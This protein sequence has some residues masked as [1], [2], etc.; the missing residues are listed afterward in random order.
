[1]KNG[2]LE[3]LQGQMFFSLVCGILFGL[4]VLGSELLHFVSGGRIPSLI[5]CLIE[6]QPPHGHVIKLEDEDDE[7]VDDN[8]ADRAKDGLIQY[9]N[10]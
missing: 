9:W 5:E 8:D 10:P 3:F 6:W 7:E 1:M 4:V 2:W